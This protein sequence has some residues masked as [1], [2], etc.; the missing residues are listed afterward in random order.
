MLRRYRGPM[1]LGPLLP[2]LCVWLV[3]G[4]ILSVVDLR[5][6]RLPNALTLPMLIVT[7]VGL[8]VADLLDSSPTAAGAGWA[9]AGLG[10]LLWLGVLGLLW[11]V[12]RGRGIGLGDVKLSP[13]L[14]A[15]LGWISL[16]TALIGL[17]MSFIAGGLVSA[18][19][20]LA[21]RVK[22]QTAIPFG[23]FLL[24]GSLVAVVIVR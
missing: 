10:A 11:L 1:D 21:K 3:V 14:G 7:P 2:L 24:L 6:H 4:V 22:R 19:L 13:S 5:E 15:T 20:L 16:E 23:P 17:V 9:G 12:S 8:A 18:V